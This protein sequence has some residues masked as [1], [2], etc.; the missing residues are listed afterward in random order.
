VTTPEPITVWAA[1]ND[2]ACPLGHMTD[3]EGVRR[4]Q[5][6]DHHPAV[7]RARGRTIAQR[8]NR[9]AGIQWGRRT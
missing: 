8:S 5:L 7:L 3:A 9:G 1:C 4:H 6:P 2:T